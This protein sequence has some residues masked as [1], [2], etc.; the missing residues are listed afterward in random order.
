MSKKQRSNY[1]W[2]KQI[3]CEIDE[4]KSRLNAIE[5]VLTNTLKDA[6]LIPPRKEKES[7]EDWLKRCVK[8]VNLEE[9]IE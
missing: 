7:W 3:Y 2:I 4:I 6:Y 1:K 9:K 5:I 8:I